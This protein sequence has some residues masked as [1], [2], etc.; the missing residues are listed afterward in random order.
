MSAKPAA[1]SLC[2]DTRRFDFEHGRI[3]APCL[4]FISGY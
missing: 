3:S 4:A 2:V 1:T